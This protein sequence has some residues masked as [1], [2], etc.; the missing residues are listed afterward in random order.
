MAFLACVLS[1]HHTL[2]HETV[3]VGGIPPALTGPVNG[4]DNDANVEYPLRSQLL[5]YL[6]PTSKPEIQGIGSGRLGLDASSGSGDMAGSSRME[7]G[8]R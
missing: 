7:W 8:A 2:P 4:K 1:T 6:L 3:G 5:H